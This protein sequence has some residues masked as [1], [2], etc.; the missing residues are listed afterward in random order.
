MDRT[1]TSPLTRTEA[2]RAAKWLAD[3]PKVA[4]ACTIE[5]VESF[6]DGTVTV[7]FLNQCNMPRHI[8]NHADLADFKAGAR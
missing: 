8:A 6:V 2:R 4:V 7:R 5:L 3:N 1:D